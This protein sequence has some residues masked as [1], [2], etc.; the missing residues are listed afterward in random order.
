M[1]EDTA[2]IMI[3]TL[4]GEL[5]KLGLKVLETKIRRPEGV[6]PGTRFSE[7]DIAIVIS[8]TRPVRVTVD[9]FLYRNRIIAEIME[10]EGKGRLSQKQEEWTAIVAEFY[11]II[12]NI[13]R[14]LGA[15]TYHLFVSAPAALTFALG[16]V[17]GLNYDVHVYHWF[18]EINDYR[19]VV[20]TSRKL[21]G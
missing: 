17:L 2:R 3:E 5:G 19:E 21:L 16:A 10:I 9:T 14:V 11:Q 13:Q 12:L 20:V 6:A 18:E 1:S 4:I 7:K 8:I 15:P